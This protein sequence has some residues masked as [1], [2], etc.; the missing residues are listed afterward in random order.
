M[1][2]R[3]ETG[4]FL[5]CREESGEIIV[6]TSEGVIKARAFRRKGSQEERWDKDI[7]LGVKGV[8]WQPVPGGPGVELRTRVFI[9]QP[10]APQE[11]VEPVRRP[12]KSRR[13]KI[14][15]EDYADHGWT[16]GCP[17]CIAMQRGGY[18]THNPRCRARMEEALGAA[19]D[20]RV[21][22]E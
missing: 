15:P 20:T 9:P 8:P 12:Y 16:I 2:A 6:G 10:V 11:P 18:Q 1:Q 17:G 13:F 7:I 5:G 4:V 22:R 14:H 3:W 21:V 19:G